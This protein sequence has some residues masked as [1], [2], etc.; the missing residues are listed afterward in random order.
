MQTSRE[1]KREAYRA[2]AE[3]ELAAL[4][5]RGVCTCGH[6]FSSVVLVKGEP[7]PE[8]LAGTAEL[9]SGADGVALRAA[10]STLGYAPEDWVGLASVDATGAP[11]EPALVREALVVLDPATVVLCDGAAAEAFRQAYA[12]EL[13]GL[14][15]FE[16]AMLAE[17]VVAHV[18]GMRVLAL[19][20]FEAALADDLRK[21]TMWVRLK[22]IPPLGEPY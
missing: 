12:D 13:A 10:L 11:L 5:E 22:Q 9:L 14:S 19:G 6:A 8:E 20:G 4:V 21:R 3:A 16:E 17:G 15:S 7:S 2:K 18:L 1:Q